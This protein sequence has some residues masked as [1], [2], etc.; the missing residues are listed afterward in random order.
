MRLPIAIL[1]LLLMSVTAF[2]AEGDGPSFLNDLSFKSMR[3][4]GTNVLGSEE[5]GSAGTIS[6]SI[7][8]A[9]IKQPMVEVQ[10]AD[11]KIHF[12]IGNQFSGTLN[13]ETDCRYYSTTDA[14]YYLCGLADASA[15]LTFLDIQQAIQQ[16][17]YF[18]AGLIC[19]LSASAGCVRLSSCVAK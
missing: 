18:S 8:K 6:I 13:Q 2:A 17:S 19:P 16:T 11:N 12:K 9:Q 1:S 10:S 14:V 3:C 4:Q 5:L 15:P 7:D